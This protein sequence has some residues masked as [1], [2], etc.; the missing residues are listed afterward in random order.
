MDN[1]GSGAL[2]LTELLDGY[3]YDARF[4]SLMKRMDIERD[5]MRT[6]FRAL[7]AD[8]SGE[9]DYVEFCH[10]LGTCKK[11]DQLM[12]STL[13][14]YAVMEVRALIEGEVMKAIEEQTGL[15]RDQLD[16][17]SHVPGCTEAA[18]EA[19]LNLIAIHEYLL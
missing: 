1:D 10:Q 8:A 2:S 15:L 13:T 14:R 17:L 7:D 4:H 5:D 12:L 9:V 11:R 6:I 3:D 16:L 18:K 19:I